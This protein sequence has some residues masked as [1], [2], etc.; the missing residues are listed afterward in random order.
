MPFPSNK[1]LMSASSPISLGSVSLINPIRNLKRSKRG[2]AH[3]PL[4]DQ[5][6]EGT[7]ECSGHSVRS[8]RVRCA[9]PIGPRR[10]SKRLAT[11]RESPHH[12]RIGRP[13]SWPLPLSHLTPADRPGSSNAPSGLPHPR[14]HQTLER[15][16]HDISVLGAPDIPASCTS[17]PPR[18]T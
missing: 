10:P 4:A 7:R 9:R 2:S 1:L 18:S 6:H 13:D 3:A 11:S 12:P 17:P 16:Q 15:P 8:R 5:V 14:P